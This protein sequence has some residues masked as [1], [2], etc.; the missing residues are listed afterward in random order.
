VI[1]WRGTI[2]TVEEVSDLLGIPR[3]TLYRYLREYSIPHLRRSGKISIPEESFDRIREARDLHKEGLGTESVRR[4][5]REG[6]AAAGSGE[7][8]ER[9]DALSE[10]LKDLQ[11]KSASDEAV[12]SPALRTM[13]ARQSLLISAVFNLTEMVEALLVANGKPRK[14]VFGEVSGDV[15]AVTP[16]PEY[17]AK[18]QLEGAG[19][20][21]TLAEPAL[22]ALTRPPE[23]VVVPERRGT[24]FGHLSRRRRTLGILAALAALLVV[25]L[26]AW[27][28]PFGDGSQETSAGAGQQPA[29]EAA[30]APSGSDGESRGSAREAANSEA[31]RE[32]DGGAPTD[33]A[34]PGLGPG[35]SQEVRQGEVPDVRGQGVEEAAQTL[36]DAG[37]TLAAI[38]TEAD[39]EEA[40][41]ATGTDPEMGTAAEPGTPV[42]L[43]VSGGPDG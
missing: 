26:L 7:L 28:L 11:E 29:R 32:G 37:Y 8:S 3:P 27:Y 21:L 33:E 31:A 38:R 43:V 10:T 39:P 42:T 23:R 22:E 15:R 20:T 24:R 4:V 35:G 41:K 25:A 12:S 6:G 34:G 5:L 13:L 36:A 9:L 19:A 2:Y 17:R 14:T 16:L 18:R 30:G 1:S 40:G